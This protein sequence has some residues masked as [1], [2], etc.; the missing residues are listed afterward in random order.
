[1]GSVAPPPADSKLRDDLYSVADQADRLIESLLEWETASPE[2]LHVELI[3]GVSAVVNEG[4]DTLRHAAERDFL[5][6]LA[7]LAR[8]DLEHRLRTLTTGAATIDG[9]EILAHCSAVLRSLVRAAAVVQGELCAAAGLEATLSCSAELELS[10]QTRTA[11]AELRLDLEAAAADLQKT[12][13]V[14][15]ALRTGATAIAKLAGREIFLRLRVRDRAQLRRLQQRILAWARAGADARV[16][17]R[18]WQD[19]FGFAQL[20]QEVNRRPVLV[21]HDQGAVVRLIEQLSG[22]R[23]AVPEEIRRQALPLLGRDDTLDRWLHTRRAI[24]AQELL[25]FLAPLKDRLGGNT[26]DEPGSD[27]DLGLGM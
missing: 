8:G 13:D 12:R 25:T 23:G 7:F 10:L 19:L 4:I 17:E 3:P 11:Y 21:E 20:L 24:E 22:R 14:A 27:L 6:D 16:G 15:K 1:M 9:I 2:R 18:L 26:A 5:A